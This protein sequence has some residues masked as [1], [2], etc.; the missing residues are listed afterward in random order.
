MCGDL[1]SIYI[2]QI[3]FCISLVYILYTQSYVCTLFPILHIFAASYILS[4]GGGGVR[5]SVHRKR[6]PVD[7]G[8]R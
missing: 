5:S 8:R 6:P 2:L 3:F 4:K 7:K 1:G